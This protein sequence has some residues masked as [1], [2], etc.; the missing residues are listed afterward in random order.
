VV[1]QAHH[2]WNNQDTVKMPFTQSLS[3]GAFG[4]LQ[5]AQNTR[6]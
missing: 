3:K 6:K 2:E 1:R 4:V 5:E